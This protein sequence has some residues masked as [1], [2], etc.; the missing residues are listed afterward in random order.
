MDLRPL[1]ELCRTEIA[2]RGFPGAAFALGNDRET[3]FG[4]AGR[5]TYDPSSPEVGSD[6]LFDLASVTKV[7]AT[8]PAAMLLFDDGKL[9]LDRSVQSY[10]PAFTGRGK[11]DVTVRNLLLHDSGLPAYAAL[12][13]YKTKEEAQDAVLRLPLPAKPGEKTVYSCMGAITLQL[14]IERLAAQPIDRLLNERFW[15]PLGMKNTLFN[16]NPAQKSRCVPTEGKIQG[17]VHD[18][19]AFACGGVSGNAGLFSTVGD[20]VGHLRFMLDKGVADGKQVICA[21]TI[22][23]WTRRPSERSTRALGW[24]TRSEQGSSA[25]TKFS[26]R[27]YGHTG[28][29]GTSVWVDPENR[30]FAALLTNRVHPKVTDRILD[31]R[32]RFHDLAFDVLTAS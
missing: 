25:G 13:K 6:A 7:M 32:P 15:T 22:E 30:I 26:R 11:E 29:T 5:F 9:D 20:V 21:K 16:P 24:D 27:S 14:V 8:T 19:A 4:F 10:L 12:S 23:E 31:F 1:V 28:Y 17:R 18:P 3:R 2:A